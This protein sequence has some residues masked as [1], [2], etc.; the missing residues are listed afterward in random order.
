MQALYALGGFC[1]INAGTV[2]LGIGRNLSDFAGEFNR[3]T[4]H[5]V[6]V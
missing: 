2:H 5:W 4:Q 6:E 1:L 3:S